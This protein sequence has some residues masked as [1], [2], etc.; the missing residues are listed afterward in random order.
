MK[1]EAQNLIDK[2]MLLGLDLETCKKCA[3]ITIDALIFDARDYEFLE[4]FYKEIKLIII[5]LI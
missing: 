1:Q 4:N 5:H 3:L 2:Y